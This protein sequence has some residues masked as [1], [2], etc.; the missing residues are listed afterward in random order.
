MP[1]A[2]HIPD[3]FLSPAVCAVTWLMAA[4][5]VWYALRRLDRALGPRMVPLL[6][7]T[8]AGIFAG[9]MVNFPLPGLATSGHLMGGVLAAVVLGPWGAVAALA[10]VLAVQALLFADGGLTALGRTSATW[11]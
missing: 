9:Q 6:G 4:V 7:V 8:A 5:G 2:M 3:G 10:T 1:L 11:P